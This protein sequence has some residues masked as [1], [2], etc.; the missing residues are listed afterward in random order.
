MKDIISML[1]LFVA[2]PVIAVIAVLRLIW[3][4]VIYGALAVDRRIDK[5]LDR[6]L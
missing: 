1:W 2:V 6:C 5:I 3:M 4:L